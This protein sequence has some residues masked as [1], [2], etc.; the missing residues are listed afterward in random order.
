MSPFALHHCPR[1]PQTMPVSTSA[2]IGETR[3]PQA[4]APLSPLGPQLST[5]PTQIWPH[6]LERTVGSL[7]YRD[8]TNP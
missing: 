2:N 8:P 4:P 7:E 6:I 3:F 5:V 1:A